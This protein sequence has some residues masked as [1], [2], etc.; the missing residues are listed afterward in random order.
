MQQYRYVSHK[1][2]A[3]RIMI[4]FTTIMLLLFL[5]VSPD[6]YA[7]T[8]EKPNINVMGVAEFQGRQ[9]ALIE[10]L[11]TGVC[12]FYRP[13]DLIYGWHLTSITSKGIQLEQNGKQ[14][15]FPIYIA[16]TVVL[17]GRKHLTES[18]NAVGPHLSFYNQ[19]YSPTDLLDKTDLPKQVIEGKTKQSASTV[20]Q[21]ESLSVQTRKKESL[22]SS[23]NL[24][25]GQFVKPLSS[26][27]I[28]SNFGYRRHP[29]YKRTRFHSGIDLAAPTGTRISAADSG[30]VVFAGWRGGYGRCVIIDHH[31]NYKTLYG[32]MSRILVSTGA[33][34]RRGSIIGA[35]GSTGVSTGPHLHFELRKNEQPVNPASKIRL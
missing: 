16:P 14:I 24:G 3:F 30:Q 20:K 27:R 10:D 26:Y 21:P 33:N 18:A 13:G 4:C 32:H 28:T 17:E 35:V 9:T 5:A 6:L 8:P 7:Q 25:R 29:V 11:N 15:D 22:R 34:V 2:S 23:I 1:R 12:A 31:N 19:E